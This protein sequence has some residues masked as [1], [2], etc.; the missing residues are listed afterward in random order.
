MQDKIDNALDLA[1]EAGRLN[2]KGL[3]SV[4]QT[5]VAGVGDE[6][7]LKFTLT[8]ES[9]L[10]VPFKVGASTL[11]DVA[12]TIVYSNGTSDPTYIKPEYGN[13]QLKSDGS[14][15][16]TSAMTTSKT[17]PIIKGA[18]TL[19]MSNL[20]VNTA[21]T[22]VTF[23]KEDG[24][25]HSSIPGEAQ[26]VRITKNIELPEDAAAFCVGIQTQDTVGKFI[27]G[28]TTLGKPTVVNKSINGAIEGTKVG[29]YKAADGSFVG[30][31]GYTSTPLIPIDG[32]AV[33]VTT[34]YRSAANGA[35][36]CFYDAS[37]SYIGCI[38]N[39]GTTGTYF[40]PKILPTKAKYITCSWMN[41]YVGS[42]GL[43]TLKFNPMSKGQTVRLSSPD[44]NT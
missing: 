33:A 21:Y 15:Q 30:S 10:E 19:T 3:V 28:Y 32:D 41:N 29:Y 2:A 36:L 14:T 16:G 43:F 20:L 26:S 9:V 13:M 11:E 31:S 38:Q 44:G 34:Y 39:P 25:I 7:M 1:E 42:V 27:I 18:T 35:T 37:E 8:D 40:L 5:T 12:T 4:E 23:F 24:S 6:N 17:Y 22:H